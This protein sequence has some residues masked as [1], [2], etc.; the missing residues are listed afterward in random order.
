MK[1]TLLFLALTAALPAATLPGVASAQVELY[2]DLQLGVFVHQGLSGSSDRNT[3]RRLDDTGSALGIRGSEDLGGGLSVVWQIE[4]DISV[5]GTDI[6]GDGS[7][8]TSDTFVGLSGAFGTLKF[9]N[10][11]D[12]LNNDMAIVDPWT[13]SVG[14]NGLGIITR[15]D[16]TLGNAIRYD[17]PD[18]GGFTASAMVGLDEDDNDAHVWSLGFGYQ[19]SDYFAKVGAIVSQH[20]SGSDKTGYVIRAEGGLESDLSIIGAVQYANQY[21]AAATGD[22]DNLWGRGVS[23]SSLASDDKLRTLELAATLSYA[24][25]NVTPRL[26]VAWGFDAKLNGEKL[27]DSGYR[28]IVIGAD[29]TLSKSTLL[30]GSAGY[31][32]YGAEEYGD[33]FHDSEWT[34]G[35]GMQKTF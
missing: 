20:Q 29:Y 30:F 24:V 22:T 7:L 3:A 23:E 11:S 1:K 4:S 28:Q 18:I 27:D 34:L 26:S 6:N 32:K 19:V 10:I 9:G 12:Y 14:V 8:A 31:V 25:G 15:F 16:G 33:G 35:V 13:Y 17:S 2:G 21:G 5:D